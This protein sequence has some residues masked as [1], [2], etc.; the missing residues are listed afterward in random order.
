M[1]LVGKMWLYKEKMHLFQRKHADM[2][3]QKAQADKAL[4]KLEAMYQEELADKIGVAFISSRSVTG[5]I[6]CLS[7]PDPL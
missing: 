4:R 6:M 7:R 5:A 2:K 3:A 1:V